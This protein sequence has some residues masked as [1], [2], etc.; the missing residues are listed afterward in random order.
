MIEQS[1]TKDL[2]FEFILREK[3]LSDKDIGWVLSKLDS[4]EYILEEVHFL[5]LVQTSEQLDKAKELFINRFFSVNLNGGCNDIMINN[6]FRGCLD[7]KKIWKILELSLGVICI[8]LSNSVTINYRYLFFS[9]SNKKCKN[10]PNIT[11]GT[12]NEQCNINKYCLEN[13]LTKSS[14]RLI[15]K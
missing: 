9:G 13:P 11:S 1:S 2:S 15:T 5:A 8:Q 4:H 7:K 12:F 6:L 3:G 10:V 14:L